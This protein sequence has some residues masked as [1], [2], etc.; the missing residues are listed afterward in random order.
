MAQPQPIIADRAEFVDALHLLRRGHLLVQCGEG[1]GSCVLGGATVY[2]SMPTLLAYGL[3]D[4]VH[5]RPLAPHVRCYKL[6][7]RGRHFADRAWTEWKRKP[8]LQRVAV[9]LM[10]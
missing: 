2:H 9:R 1:T 3:L 5:E 8:L 7:P 10:G 4:P 6:S